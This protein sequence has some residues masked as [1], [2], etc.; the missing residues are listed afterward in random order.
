MKKS[1]GCAHILQLICAN[2]NVEGNDNNYQS[3]ETAYRLGRNLSAVPL[4]R[5]LLSG[6][7]EISFF[8]RV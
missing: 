1:Q 3:E 8:L 2:K 6:P 4:M 5:S 7:M